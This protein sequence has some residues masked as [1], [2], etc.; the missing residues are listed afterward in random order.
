MYRDPDVVI[1]ETVENLRLLAEFFSDE[2]DTLSLNS[3]QTP[4][5]H[6]IREARSAIIALVPKLQAA[7]ESQRQPAS[8]QF[9]W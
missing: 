9:Q 4:A 6:R 8:E 1:E 2:I 3:L 5:L 7:R